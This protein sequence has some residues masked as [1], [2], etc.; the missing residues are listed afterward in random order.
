METNSNNEKPTL[1]AVDDNPDSLNV[2]NQ[3]LSDQ[4]YQV[5]IANSGIQALGILQ[6]I[7]V[8][9]ILLDAMMP[10]MDG[11]ETCLAIK[12]I[13]PDIPII[14]MTGLSETEHI[15][16]GLSKGAVDYLVK[17]INHAELIA[18][19]V[20][21][22][23][24]AQQAMNTKKA[25]DSTGQY[26]A[27]INPDGQINWTTLQAKTYINALNV[28]DLSL[29]TRW[30]ESA[31]TD[32]S[33]DLQH[34]DNTLKLTYLSLQKDGSHLIKFKSMDLKLAKQTLKLKLKITRREADVLYWVAQGKTDWEISQILNIS[35]RTVNKHLE[36]I[37][38]KL[39]VNN[40]T[41]ASTYAIQ[42]LN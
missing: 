10:G 13:N 14:F 7:N 42:A 15:V 36:Q 31:Q 5:L 21:H 2:L 40:R 6:K 20:V 23:N 16:T 34:D 12:H 3:T 27:A 39:G 33:L 37:Y 26:L 32:D 24:N 38:R 25:L 41:S 29:L 22:I 17:P 19:V 1:L 8:D 28:K 35:E 30:L 9:L 18:R 4:G 11:F